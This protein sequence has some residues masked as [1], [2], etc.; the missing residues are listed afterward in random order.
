[1]D[2]QTE[3]KAAHKAVEVAEKI[4]ALMKMQG[5]KEYIGVIDRL[6][7]QEMK[8]LRGQKMDHLYYKRIGFLQMMY[9]I[10]A[11]P[12]LVKEKK[13]REYLLHQGR[14][15]ALETVKDEIPGLFKKQKSLAIQKIK[16]MMT[17]IDL[18][19]YKEQHGQQVF[20]EM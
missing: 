10:K 3:I 2:N 19:Q 18:D 11:I 8:A 13:V 7:T 17:G 14:A 15:K 5:W 6:L 20:E 12:D 9:F 1:M 4:E 16:Q